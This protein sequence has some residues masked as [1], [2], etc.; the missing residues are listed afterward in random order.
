MCVRCRKVYNPYSQSTILVNCG[1]CEECQQDKADNRALRIRNSIGKD[2]VN[3][4]VT[5]TYK[6][7]FLPVV[8][9]S[10][11]VAQEDIPIYRRRIVHVKKGGSFV[12]SPVLFN[13]IGIVVLDKLPYGY[14]SKW[15]RTPKHYNDNS[16][17]SICFYRDIQ[18]FFKRLRVN[19]QRDILKNH[20]N[21]ATKFKYYSCSEYGPTTHRSHF[22]LVLTVP[23]KS[24][25]FFRSHIIKAWPFADSNITAR[26]IEV[27]RCCSNYVASYVNCGSRLP[28]VLSDTR[29]KPRHSYSKS[30]GLASSEFSAYEVFKK[31]QRGN[32]TYHSPVA[33]HT[34]GLDSVLL[35]KYVLNRHFPLFKGFSRIVPDELFRVLLRPVYRSRINLI[36]DEGFKS[37]VVVSTFRPFIDA[38]Y[39]PE[40]IHK[41]CVSLDNHCKKFCDSV[42]RCLPPDEPTFKPLDY[43][44]TY[45]LAW[46]LYQ[47]NKYRLFLEDAEFNLPYHPYNSNYDNIE[48]IFNLNVRVDKSVFPVSSSLKYV[49]PNSLPL[50]V[51]AHNRQLYRYN[52]LCKEKKVLNHTMSKIGIDV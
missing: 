25:E 42:N 40:D 28:K 29:F 14:D 17:V 49:D 23:A 6:N 46:K 39:T 21:Y 38:G 31:V 18:N 52:K 20:L 1:K 15:L 2:E 50:R 41:I 3:L 43:Y 33:S 7:D 13:Q 44:A 10:D 47:S 12:V 51:F 37:L 48:D 19:M 26:G 5:L 32:L 34:Y 45:L 22:H 27:A 4:F 8:R 16:F 9:K 24:V 11:I 30:Y 36:T 35:P